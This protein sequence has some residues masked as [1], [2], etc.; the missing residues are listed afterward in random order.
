MQSDVAAAL[1]TAEQF[2]N[3]IARVDYSSAHGLL[4]QAA[5]ISYSPSEIRWTVEAM[6]AC[7][8][9]TIRAVQV[10]E[11]QVRVDWPEKQPGDVASVLVRLVGD[12][13]VEAVTVI[14]AKEDD[15]VR[16]RHL[17]WGRPLSAV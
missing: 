11:E 15:A 8:A 4:T 13:F 14:L 12:V 7:M 16:I 1:R 10:P 9:G 2:G 5:R 17:E 6:T 3:L